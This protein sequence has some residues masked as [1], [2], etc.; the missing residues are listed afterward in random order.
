MSKNNVPRQRL[1]DE[2]GASIAQNISDPSHKAQR[3]VIRRSPHR[4]V[5]VITLPWFQPDPIEWESQLERSCIYASVALWAVKRIAHQPYRIPMPPGGP[6]LHYT[7]DFALTLIDGTEIVV[8]VKPS[9]FVAENETRLHAAQA[10]LSKQ[11]IEFVVLTEKQLA[12]RAWAHIVPM[13]LRYARWDPDPALIANVIKRLQDAGCKARAADLWDDANPFTRIP[14]YHLIG[15]REILCDPR[16]W[17]DG[18]TNVSLPNK[19]VINSIT[20]GDANE[21]EELA[22][23]TDLF[24]QWF[25]VTPWCPHPAVQTAD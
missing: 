5:G 4:N 9:R 3:R 20:E 2:D 8:E 11:G 14:V 17:R 7:P 1:A 13:F 18:Q 23:A 15:R 24:L 19:A 12:H 16:E 21:R 10:W 25:G 6:E 22:T